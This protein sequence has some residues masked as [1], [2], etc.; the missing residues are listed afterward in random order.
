MQP[1]PLS[2]VIISENA[3]DRQSYVRL[4][5]DLPG[6]VLLAEVDLVCQMGKQAGHLDVKCVVLDI[7]R[8]P[9][10]GLLSLM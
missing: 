3:P 6:V 7:D 4:M 9:R 10:A 8:Y 5:Q 2:V 1:I